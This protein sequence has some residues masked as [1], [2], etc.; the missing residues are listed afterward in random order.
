MAGKH[1]EDKENMGCAEDISNEVVAWDVTDMNDDGKE[2]VL[3][4][5]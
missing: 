1:N 4:V 2:N 3:F 5:C